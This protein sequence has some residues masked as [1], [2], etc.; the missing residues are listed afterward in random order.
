MP[1]RRQVTWHGLT[2]LVDLAIKKMPD[3]IK[4]YPMLTIGR[5]GVIVSGLLQYRLSNKN[6][7]I[8]GLESY[9]RG[10][11]EQEEVVPLSCNCIARNMY[12]NMLLIDDLADTGKTVQW[13]I[14][15]YPSTKFHLVTALR[16][17]KCADLGIP[18]Y[19][20]G[21]VMSDVWVDFP[22]GE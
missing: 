19:F 10:A 17:K 9:Y 21:E 14:N 5:G 18:H 15:A 2:E 6:N 1:R 13:M 20:G 16:K 7:Q 3:E 4:Q 12:D 22:W 8:I 11:G